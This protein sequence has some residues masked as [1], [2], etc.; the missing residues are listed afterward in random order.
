MLPD[1]L[2]PEVDETPTVAFHPSLLMGTTNSYAALFS[3]GLSFHSAS[4]HSAETIDLVPPRKADCATRARPH[5]S[6]LRFE[7]STSFRPFGCAFGH[8]LVSQ[9][10]Y[11]GETLFLS[12]RPKHASGRS[13]T[14]G[15]AQQT[16]IRHSEMVSL[17][18]RGS[19]QAR[20]DHASL[21]RI[22]YPTA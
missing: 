18:S 5:N 1:F 8:P 9:R 21:Q 15:E 14:N 10:P 7:C 13:N 22:P 2:C 17:V 20:N 3:F 19:Q 16:I 4:L 6:P 11:E 12:Q